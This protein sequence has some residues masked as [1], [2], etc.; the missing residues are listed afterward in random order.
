M[1]LK[2]AWMHDVDVLLCAASE[3]DIYVP[4]N[5]QS[6][7][8]LRQVSAYLIYQHFRNNSTTMA[9]LQVD[10]LQVTRIVIIFAVL[11]PIAKVCNIL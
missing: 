1:W 2:L 5:L 3:T 8:S 9:D 7:R 11:I 4:V 6:G 10:L